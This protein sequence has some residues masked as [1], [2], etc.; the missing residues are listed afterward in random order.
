MEDV[1]LVL[2]ERKSIIPLSYIFI[3]LMAYYGPNANLIGNIKL[4]IWQYQSPITD[5]EALVYNVG[6]LSLVDLSSFAING[7]L[8][9][10]F[11]GINLMKTLKSLQQEFFKNHSK[12]FTSL[13]DILKLLQLQKNV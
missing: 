13:P 2:S 6:L 7:I 1:L 3:V 5:I 11:C 9:W 8:L 4:T 10:F 12:I